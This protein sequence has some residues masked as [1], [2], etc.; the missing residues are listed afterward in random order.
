M[1]LSASDTHP[2]DTSTLPPLL[3]NLPQAS[4]TMHSAGHARQPVSNRR[5][6]S[7]SRPWNMLQPSVKVTGD[8]IFVL[9]TAL[10][11]RLGLAP[12][13]FNL[14]L[15]IGGDM[16][17]HP[18]CTGNAYCSSKDQS[19]LQLKIG[20]GCHQV[21]TMVHNKFHRGWRHPDVDTL[22]MVLS[23]TDKSRMSLEQCLV[24]NCNANGPVWRMKWK[25]CGVEVSHEEHGCNRHI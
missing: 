23:A 14:L 11:E 12:R 25:F 3:S 9:R 8:S 16:Q 13:R 6:A 2:L 4:L 21:R 18:A 7:C 20:A 17:Q 1:Q 15:E 10:V 22:V 24:S 5:N 19:W